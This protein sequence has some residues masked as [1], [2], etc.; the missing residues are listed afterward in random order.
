MM[1]VKPWATLWVAQVEWERE[2]VA[3]LSSAE[4]CECEMHRDY[5]ASLT[6]KPAAKVAR[7]VT[8]ADIASRMERNAETL[9]RTKGE[10]ADFLRT[11]AS[12]N[13]PA[14]VNMGLRRRPGALTDR[15]LGRWSRLTARS[16]SLRHR[17]TLDRERLRRL[18]A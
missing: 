11:N 8:A 14:V 1:T 18:A 10:L 6:A 3:H 15:K 5:R 12:H 9:I 13:D 17:L 2:T 7:K 16:E 4:P